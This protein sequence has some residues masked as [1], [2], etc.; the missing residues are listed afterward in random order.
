[1]DDNLL[2]KLSEQVGKQAGDLR[3]VICSPLANEV[4]PETVL[5]LYSP[6]SDGAMRGARA[7]EKGIPAF[8]TLVA[9]GISF[10]TVCTLL[11]GCLSEM[12]EDAQRVC[13]RA[14]EEDLGGGW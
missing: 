4:S 7:F 14:L 6:S 12:A 3:L 11:Q 1:M 5:R 2:A 8:D 13:I 9:S 10:G